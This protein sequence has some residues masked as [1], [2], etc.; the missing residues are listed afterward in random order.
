M[1]KIFFSKEDCEYIKSFWD[2]DLRISGKEYNIVKS[3]LDTL[4]IRHDANGY[5]V[6]QPD[7]K[8][9]RFILDR[10]KDT[11]IKS[12]IFLACLEENMHPIYLMK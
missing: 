10:V 7:E 9:I 3:G 5:C 12:N 6:N 8:L 11:F 4:V 1:S 2:D